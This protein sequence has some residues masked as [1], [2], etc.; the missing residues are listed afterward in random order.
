MDYGLP[1]PSDFGLPNPRQGVFHPPPGRVL[2]IMSSATCVAA[3]LFW[4]FSITQTDLH[5]VK[6]CKSE[7]YLKIFIFFGHF[8]YLVQVVIILHKNLKQKSSYNYQF[9]SKTEKKCQNYCILELGGQPIRRRRIRLL[10]A[11][12]LRACSSERRERPWPDSTLSAS[13]VT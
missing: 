8:F 6:L 1:L 2:E 12:W 11:D 7:K 13:H 10:H 4:I 5:R 9:C 3:I